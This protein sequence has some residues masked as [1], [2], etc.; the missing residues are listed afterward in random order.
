MTSLH[1]LFQWGIEHQGNSSSSSINSPQTKRELS[2]FDRNFLNAA[3]RSDA[4]KMKGI[5]DI[6][7]SKDS[8]LEEKEIALEDLEFFVQTIDNACDLS[9]S[10]VNG[11]KVLLDAIRYDRK[12][13]NKQGDFFHSSQVRMRAAWVLATALQNNP[14]LQAE[15]QNEDA[16]HILTETLNQEISILSLFSIESKK[17]NE[18]QSTLEFLERG[19]LSLI[20]KLI[21]AISP[22]LNSK[23]AIKQFREES[24]FHSLNVLLRMKKENI[25]WISDERRALTI[26]R[27]NQLFTQQEDERLIEMIDK[28]I[29]EEEKNQNQSDISDV[30]DDVRNRA[31]VLQ[32]QRAIIRMQRKLNLNEREKAIE[33]DYSLWLRCARRTMF[34][35]KR[36]MDNHDEMKYA[37][38]KDLEGE[39]I[40]TMSMILHSHSEDP[41]LREKTV[42]ALSTLLF[43]GNVLQNRAL[44]DLKANHSSFIQ[45]LLSNVM[46]AQKMEGDESNCRESFDQIINSLRK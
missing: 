6:Y 36:I 39:T 43:G 16:L 26:Q 40:Q 19:D 4:S 14:K 22:L 46:D 38:I 15:A 11:L 33:D 2:Q 29:E 21:F 27:E 31:R 44:Q 24:G 12:D 37:F 23:L 30:E 18:E 34:T 7:Q 17:S 10:T 45:E 9:H 25:N 8:T 32:K 41:D 5:L 1:Q 28:Q 35:L 13:P 3:M 42:L 20:A